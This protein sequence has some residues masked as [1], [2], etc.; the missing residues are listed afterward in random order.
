MSIITYT[1]NG[2]INAETGWYSYYWTGI[3]G[4]GLF[5]PAGASIVGDHFW[6][7][8]IA[9]DCECIGAAGNALIGAI[10]P[11]PNPIQ[12]VTLS[13]G[14]Q[15]YGHNPVVDFGA[16]FAYGEFFLAPPYHGLNLQQ[17][18]TL[19]GGGAIISTSFGFS[20]NPEGPNGGFRIGN[21]SGLFTGMAVGIPAPEI[22]AG[23]PGVILALG[24]IVWLARRRR[25]RSAP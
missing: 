16:N 18:G 3:D 4:S 9:T 20:G 17:A 12:D 14:N 1:V 5:G 21:T 15:P 8:W 22:G 13:I 24:I 23:Y 2:T 10:Y 11:Q 7:T 6:V 25:G 19:T